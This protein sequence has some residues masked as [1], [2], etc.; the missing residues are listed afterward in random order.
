MTGWEETPAI[1]RRLITV[2]AQDQTAGIHEAPE[3]T[4]WLGQRVRDLSR[5]G[6]V[7]RLERALLGSSYLV[8]TLGAA[9]RDGP[10]SLRRRLWQRRWP[11]PV[12]GAETLAA[13][14][15]FDAGHPL[16]DRSYLLHP[17]HDN[18]YLLPV[19]APAELARQKVAAFFDLV[20]ALGARSVELVSAACLDSLPGGA[21][22]AALVYAA[23]R[24]AIQAGFDG[25]GRLGR[26]VLAEY[27]RPSR[28]P[29]VPELLT[30]WVNLAPELRALVHARLDAKVNR[31]QVTLIL[32]QELELH[33]DFLFASVAAGLK[34]GELTR[35]LPV[36]LWTFHVDFGAKKGV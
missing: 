21:V 17:L 28:E 26:R 12:F 9:G 20:A 36:T 6:T 32:G 8:P 25:K 31:Y 18:T 1:R 7:S 23:A 22:R 10:G 15:I 16:P 29:F 3:L 5:L 30:G 11:W 13:H 34:I 2:T 19:G 27:P 14:A 33:P 24:A 4:R 35:P